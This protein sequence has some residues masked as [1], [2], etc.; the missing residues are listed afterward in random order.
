MGEWQGWGGLG[1]SVDIRL[2]V[3]RVDREDATIHYAA[4]DSSGRRALHRLTCA[5]EGET[6]ASTTDGGERFAL[7]RRNEDT[8]E[9]LW[10]LPDGGWMCGVVARVD[11]RCRQSVERIPLPGTADTLEVRVFAPD[12]TGPFPTLLFNHGSTGDGTD[13]SLFALTWT[14]LPLARHFTERGWLVAFPQRRGRGDSDGRYDEGF[15]PSRKGYSTNAPTALAGLDHALGDVG[16]S[17]AWATSHADIDA[18]RLVIGG[19]SRGGALAIA[20]LGEHGAAFRGALS[21]VGGWLG[22][23]AASAA[24][25]NA[26]AFARGASFEGDTLWLH[27]DGDA[28]YSLEHSRASFARFEEAGGTGTFR[29]VAVPPGTDAH[30]IVFAPE[31]WEEPVT[32]Y[33]EAF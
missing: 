10:N 28:Y 2:L 5:V 31:L 26:A 14:C 15:K 23:G 1:M 29:T 13:P 3:E 24:R 33:I 9:F 25:V 30:Q 6:L 27:A 21:F 22:D 4:A 7:R 17:I 11:P 12:G 18:E 8:A 32:R 20:A 16:A 19:Q